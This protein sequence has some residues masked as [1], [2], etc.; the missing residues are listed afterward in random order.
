MYHCYLHFPGLV[1][2]EGKAQAVATNDTSSCNLIQIVMLH[3]E[4]HSTYAMVFLVCVYI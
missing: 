4:V 3:G 2:H 1:R